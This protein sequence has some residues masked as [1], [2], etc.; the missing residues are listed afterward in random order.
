MMHTLLM[1][2]EARV[3]IFILGFP[4]GSNCKESACSVG[5]VVSIPGLKRSPGEENKYPFQYSCLEN[6]IDKGAWRA[7]VHGVT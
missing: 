1:C 4:D 2:L 6:S 7:V 5:N 3:L